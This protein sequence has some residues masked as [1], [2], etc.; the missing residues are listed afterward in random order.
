MSFLSDLFQFIEKGGWVAYVLAVLTL[1]LWYAMGFR[2]FYLRSKQI[3]IPPR[4]AAQDGKIE[5]EDLLSEALFRIKNLAGQSLSDLELAFHLETTRFIQK[6]NEQRQWIRS[7]V[8]VAPLLGLLGTVIGMIET[9]DSLQ[10]QALFSQSGG[11]AGGISQAL[12]TTEMGLVVAIP[13][14]LIGRYLDRRQEEM[15]D[16][17]EQFKHQI[18]SLKGSV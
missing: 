2:F 6:I 9:F 3:D 15:L 8:V 17:L 14:L 1:G 5:G 16:Y 10:D 13:G 11:I 7:I 12:I 4:Q 18:L